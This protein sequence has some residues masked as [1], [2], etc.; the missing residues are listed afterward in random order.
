MRSLA[1]TVNYILPQLSASSGQ[2]PPMVRR[3]LEVN[4]RFFYQYL[5][6]SPIAADYIDS[7]KGIDFHSSVRVVCLNKGTELVRF[8]HI[9]LEF[10]PQKGQSPSGKPFMYA[11]KPGYSNSQLGINF[12][13]YRFSRINLLES[14]MALE[15][16]AADM[17]WDNRMRPGG[18]LQ[19]ILP[20]SVWHDEYFSNRCGLG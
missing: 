19:Y 3:G 17:K 4:V 5:G 8:N 2:C 16:T 13:R 14:V 7:I 18:G 15:S 11:T 9:A 6:T 12:R 20:R 10:D 1:E